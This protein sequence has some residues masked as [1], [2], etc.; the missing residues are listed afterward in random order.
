MILVAADSASAAL[1]HLADMTAIT[2]P[3]PKPLLFPASTEADM[4]PATGP[5]AIASRLCSS[6]APTPPSA[7]CA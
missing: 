5:V 1:L 7:N 6:T 3:G 2:P 4:R